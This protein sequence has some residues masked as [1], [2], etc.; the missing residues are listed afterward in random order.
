MLRTSTRTYSTS[1]PGTYSTST[2]PGTCGTSST[3]GT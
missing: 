1:T 3:T 2:P